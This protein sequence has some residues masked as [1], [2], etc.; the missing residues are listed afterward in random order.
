LPILTAATWFGTGDGGAGGRCGR[1][2][3]MLITKST[4]R[5]IIKQRFNVTLVLDV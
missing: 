2:A 4:V 3:G 1:H 5:R